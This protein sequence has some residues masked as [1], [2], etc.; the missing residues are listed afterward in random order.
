MARHSRELRRQG[1]APEIVS[2]PVA[3]L[4]RFVEL[5]DEHSPLWRAQF[6]HESKAAMLVRIARVETN[7]RTVLAARREPDGRLRVRL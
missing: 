5:L 2:I 3:K 1:R 4:R 6:G 7:N